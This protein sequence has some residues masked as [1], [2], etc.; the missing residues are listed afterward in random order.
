MQI[1]AQSINYGMDRYVL[2][3]STKANVIETQSKHETMLAIIKLV[4]LFWR[5]DFY[6]VNLINCLFEG[7]FWSSDFTYDLCA[8][9]I[10]LKPCLRTIYTRTTSLKGWCKRRD[11]CCSHGVNATHTI[12]RRQIVSSKRPLTPYLPYLKLAMK[13][14]WRKEKGERL[15][16]PNIRTERRCL[17]KH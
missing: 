13:I 5:Y 1:C 15:T 4:F 3:S 11:S 10:G 12:N 14:K 6:N 7:R 17:L 16:A 9:D 8:C 2:H